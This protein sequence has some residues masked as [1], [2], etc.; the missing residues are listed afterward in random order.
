[1]RAFE[2]FIKYVKVHTASAEDADQTPTTARQ[3]DLSHILADEMRGLGMAEVHVDEQA[4]VYGSIPAS[5]GLEA[6]P[7]I[8]FIAHIDTI[9][10]FSGENVRP[11]LIENYDGRDVALGGSGLVL[12]A[13]KF[14]GLREL[15]GHTLITTDG[16]TVLGADDKA[17]IAE[18]MTACERIINEDIPH[19][20]IAVCFTPDEEVGH[21]AQL[22]KLERLAA[23]FAF[24]V[25]GE[26]LDEISFETFNAAGASWEI[27]GV[28][29]HPGSA[30]NVMINASLVAMEINSMLPSGDTPAKTEGREGFFHLMAMQGDVHSAKLSYIVRDHSAGGFEAR[31]QM[32]RHI[33]SLINEKYGEGTARLEITEQY[34]NM[35]ELFNGHM[36]I[37]SLAEAAVA[38]AGLE[39]VTT[40][41]RGGTDGAQLS[42]RGLLCPNI[43][44]GG[45][46]CHGPYE[47]ISAENMDRAVDIIL[48]I[49]EGSIK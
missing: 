1:M 16:T 41:I 36:D 30:K 19:G 33:E 43:G 37:V 35:A 31:K 10:D 4:Y 6:K 47:H 14:P 20:K 9:P 17:G 2:R 21:G 11:Q 25:D 8:G 38:K 15:K 40:A 46:G 45:D 28:N 34:R 18:I 23:D 24:T 39:P 26:A 13:D 22:L 49:I 3:F 42:F 5:A 27:S 29:V 7:C 32:L 48:N 44:T 12:S